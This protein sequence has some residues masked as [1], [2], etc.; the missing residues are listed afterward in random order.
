LLPIPVF[1]EGAYN[2]SD[3]I[4]IITSKHV[5]K[6]NIPFSIGKALYLEKNRSAIGQSLH[7]HEF[8][9][10]ALVANGNGFHY[11]GEMK[12][13]VKKGDLFIINFK[14][15]HVFV[16]IDRKNSGNLVIINCL[17]MPSF[18]ENVAIALDSLDDIINIVLFKSLYIK[19]IDYKRDLC[20][21]EQALNT[22]ISINERMYEL[23]LLYDKNEHNPYKTDQ[24]KLLLCDLLIN[25][26]K[27]YSYKIKDFPQ[28]DIYRYKLVR[29][30]VSF[31]HNNYHKNLKLE[32]IA[33]SAF[34]SKSHFSRKF[35]ELTG[36][37]LFYY[38]HKLRVNEAYNLIRT[39]HESFD[40]IA[41]LVGYNDYKFFYRKFKEIMGITPSQ[42]RSGCVS[43]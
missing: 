36:E 1:A 16:P 3:S 29:N 4:N 25:I 41:R 30:I 34:L 31:I 42:A 28:E 43:M 11:L 13:D 17:F 18:I 6:K 39:T 20:L 35:K 10:I 21:S 14:T 37:S 27:E 24:L 19:E 15:P 40:N 7:R 38:I 12:Y 23:Y 33:R 5:F 9:E 8:I 26:F 22:I 32:N 2:M